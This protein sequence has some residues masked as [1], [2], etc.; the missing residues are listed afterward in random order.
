MTLRPFQYSEFNYL[1][2]E[3]RLLT[4]HPGN[5]NDPITCQLEHVH[6]DSANEYTALSYT[7]GS[8]LNPGLIIIND[9]Y[10]LSVTANLKDAL[11]HMR[12]ETTRR[13][14]WIDAICINQN[15]ISERNKQVQYM[16]DIYAQ[17][18]C[19]EAW[20]G[21]ASDANYDALSLV[22]QISQ[23]IPDHEALLSSGGMVEQNMKLEIIFD[24]STS[25]LIIALNDLFQ[26]PW[27]N[28]V[29]IVQELSVA[30]QLAA[31]VRYG[32]ATVSW[33]D[34]LVSAYV[35]EAY[36]NLL[37]DILGLKVPD[38]RLDG[39]LNGIRMAQCRRTQESQ[40]WLHLLELLNV[41]RDCA[42]TDPRDHIYGLLGLSGDGHD[43]GLMPNY[44][45]SVQ[46]IYKDLAVK[47]I[48]TTRSLDIICGCRGN[49]NFVNLP[50]WVP[51]WS[52]NQVISS[53]C[54]YER[55][56]GGDVITGSSTGQNERY[57][58]SSSFY[59][60]VSFRQSATELVTNGFAFGRVVALSPIDNKLTF[61][62]V[63]SFGK[64]GPNG[65]SNSGSEV[66]DH[67]LDL[68]LEDENCTRLQRRYGNRIYDAFSRTLVANR[69]YKVRKP[70]IRDEDQDFSEEMDEEKLSSVE[71][72]DEEHEDEDQSTIAHDDK[73]ED[74][75]DGIQVF[76]PMT[77]LS[78]S[79]AE[80][81]LCIQVSWGKRL[82]ILDTGYLGIVPGHCEIGDSAYVLLG[83]SLP[84]ILRTKGTIELS[85]PFD[86]ERY[87]LIGES[88]F[89]GV[90]DGELMEEGGGNDRNNM[91]KLVL[92]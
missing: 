68:L 26:R 33:I 15:N 74:E 7:W 79:A 24:N 78:M 76:S 46:D 29:W 30:K 70:P 51:D 14:L 67:W 10:T 66:F 59:A 16:R 71:I 61:E 80:F 75:E 5:F 17:A 39:Y 4:L 2:N 90:T 60:D 64:S 62:N 35:M 69:N 77:I 18:S 91:T 27:W 9:Y 44:N 34:L 89:H 57:R 11:L 28:R 82:A 13:K 65:K 53:I 45:L 1:S 40:P 36:A 32:N 37:S 84:I 23:S 81:A 22:Q 12:Q 87:V 47:H 42:S 3:I 25:E 52:S 92:I 72:S 43:M 41:H 83:C 49:R 38:E 55:F 86:H 73:H 50:S 56:C 63:Q 58:T 31:K 54:I 20:L 8:L 6:L 21:K 88:Y 48:S 85:S 19:V